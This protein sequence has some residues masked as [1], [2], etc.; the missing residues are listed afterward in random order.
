[1]SVYLNSL[2]RQIDNVAELSSICRGEWCRT[3]ESEVDSLRE[4]VTVASHREPTSERTRI[5]KM[6]NKISEAYRH[7][8]PDIH[9]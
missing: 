7:L 1:M 8:A 4:Q 3:L 2:E 9:V 6:S 5:G